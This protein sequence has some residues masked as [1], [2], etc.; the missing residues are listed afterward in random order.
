MPR[1]SDHSSSCGECTSFE[2]C[3]WCASSNS[4]TSMS[5]ALKS[6]CRGMVFDPPCPSVIVEENLVVGDLVVHA[7]PV[8]GGGDF[9]TAG[10]FFILFMFKNVFI[11]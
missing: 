8:F 3:V 10:K 4:C 6:D 9:V 5:A 2:E 1:C 7:D 11:I